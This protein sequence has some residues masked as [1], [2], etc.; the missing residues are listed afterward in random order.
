MTTC[1]FPSNVY[2]AVTY[3]VFSLFPLFRDNPPV[4]CILSPVS[5][6]LTPHSALITLSPVGEVGGIGMGA[7]VKL[8]SFE[9][10]GPLL[11][12]SVDPTRK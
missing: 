3:F 10:V 9:V 5:C 6:L 1:L 12:P 4:Y 7:V 2:L 8:I 11:D